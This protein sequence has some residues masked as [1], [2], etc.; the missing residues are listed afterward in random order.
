MTLAGKAP[1]SVQLD[2]IESSA[3]PGVYSSQVTE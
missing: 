3:T 2:V 1:W